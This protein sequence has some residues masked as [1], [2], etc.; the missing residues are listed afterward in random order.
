MPTSGTE[1]PGAVGAGAADAAYFQRCYHRLLRHAWCDEDFCARLA[2]EPAETLA[3]YG[4]ALPPNI[5]LRIEFVDDGIDL[6]RLFLS[7]DAA[8]L[9]GEFTVMVPAVHGTHLSNE[10]LYSIIGG[11]FLEA[12]YRRPVVYIRTL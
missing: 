10:D 6:D 9:S 3:R 4:L 2:D 5:R 12:R 7:W 8:W 11:S 1:G